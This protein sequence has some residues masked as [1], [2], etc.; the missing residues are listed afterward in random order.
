MANKNEIPPT[1]GNRALEMIMRDVLDHMEEISL[2]SGFS[3][4]EGC[5]EIIEIAPERP[6]APVAAAEEP[7]KDEDG[8]V[9]ELRPLRAAG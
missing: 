2:Q 9:V 3:P 6:A 8:T 4:A 1:I 7:D 5:F